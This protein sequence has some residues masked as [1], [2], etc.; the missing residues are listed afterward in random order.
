MALSHP[1]P[2]P[3]MLTIYGPKSGKYCDGLSRRSFLQLGGLATGAL[4]LPNLLQRDAAAK[5][6]SVGRR[7]K[8][9]IMICLGGG[10]SHLDMYDMRP[11]APVEYRGEFQPIASS[12]PGMQMCELM[13]RQAEIA[14]RFS[15]VRSLQWQE[16]CHQF[17][18]ICTGFPTK[19]AR[20]SFG[21]LVNRLYTG[22]SGQLPRF[23]DLA[24]DGDK[25]KAE[26][27]RYAGSAY[28]AFSPHG[29]DLENLSLARG[30]F[31]GS[32]Q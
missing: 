17:S 21:S 13:P 12:V 10:P 18:E 24:G 6:A 23:I 19:E 1:C 15:V 26:A 2:L 16:P 32:T 25:V 3:T 4:S 7:G 5:Q 22:G 14:H 11:E 20:P 9:I 30:R 31:A 8:S 28:R 29:P 27:P